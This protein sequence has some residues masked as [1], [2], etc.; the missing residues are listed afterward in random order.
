MAQAISGGPNRHFEQTIAPLSN[1]HPWDFSKELVR[2]VSVKKNEMFFPGLVCLQQIRAGPL[3]HLSMLGASMES[4]CKF[5]CTFHGQGCD[6]AEIQFR[7]NGKKHKHPRNPWDVMG[8]QVATFFE[9]PGVSRLE[10]L[11]FP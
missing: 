6:E 1:K 11:V 2:H 9:A 8:C 5:L 10:G 4:L 3:F 7:R